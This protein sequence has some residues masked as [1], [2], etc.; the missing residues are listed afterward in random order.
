MISDYGLLPVKHIREKS[1]GGSKQRA[2]LPPMGADVGSEMMGTSS[3]DGWIAPEVADG[4]EHTQQSD[5]YSYGGVLYE[6]SAFFF[7]LERN[8]CKP[9]SKRKPIVALFI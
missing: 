3:D 8:I 1:L 2:G 6:V 9:V 4:E 5:L 7:G